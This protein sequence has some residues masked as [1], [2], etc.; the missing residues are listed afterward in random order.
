[1]KTKFERVS[2]LPPYVF[3]EINNLKAKE[4]LKGRD[5][6]DLGMGNPDSP[7]PKH[8]VNK[9]ISTIK[10]PKTH[11]YSISRGIEGLR[12]AQKK[13]YLRRFNVNLHKEWEK[14]RIKNSDYH[15]LKKNS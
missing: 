2:L 6:I 12:K 9:M 1:M 7:T 8:I 15:P 4:R 13:Y 14:R 5:I 3:S 11:R 10:N